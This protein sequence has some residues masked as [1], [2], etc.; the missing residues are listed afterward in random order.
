MTMTTENRAILNDA[1]LLAVRDA[2]FARMQ[3]L[4]QSAPSQPFYLAGVLAQGKVDPYLEPE[5]WIDECLD[6]LTK[7]ADAAR[8]AAVFRPLVVEFGLYGVHFVDKIFGAEVFELG[9]KNNWQVRELGTE[10]GTL[11]VP[12]LEGD[13]SWQLACRAAEAFVQAEV[14]LPLFGLPTIASALN[15]GLNLYGQEILFMMLE[16]PE[17]VHHDLRIIND[18][19]LAM[20]RWYLD[21][22]PLD[23]LQPVVGFERTQVPGRGQ[24]CGC[25][26]QLISPAQYDEFIAPLD[27]ELLAVY[28]E[29]GMIHLCGTHTQCLPAW[30]AMESLGSLQ[31]TDRASEDLGLYL[32]GL[33]EDQVV[34]VNPCATMPIPE[35]LKIS[36]GG[37][38]VVI[39]GEPI[40][41]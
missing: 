17:A 30:R 9:E 3:R 16:E 13:P 4:Y 1:T 22:L 41:E 32:E 21:R 8:D 11:K 38:R 37:N 26:T 28:P 12:D 5:R 18:V 24:L 40:S 19:L 31:V 25:S 34:Y 15:V 36:N 35:I 2:H 7:R 14:R 23:Q 27:A 6:D 10:V 33:R 39:V 20:H 29:P